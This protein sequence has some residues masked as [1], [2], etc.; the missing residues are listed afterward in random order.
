MKNRDIGDLKKKQ[1]QMVT[2]IID[3]EVIYNHGKHLRK[4][5]YYIKEIKTGHKQNVKSPK[6]NNEGRYSCSKEE[7][8]Q[9]GKEDTG[10]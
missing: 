2:R 1:K 4:S 8:F 5:R 10:A 3:K 7:N 9:E 6:G